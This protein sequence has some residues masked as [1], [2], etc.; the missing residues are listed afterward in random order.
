MKVSNSLL[1]VR[2]SFV[3]GLQPGV[4]VQPGVREDVG[5]MRNHFTGCVKLEKK[6]VISNE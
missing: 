5:G 1:K 3:I 6:I 2:Q 4:R